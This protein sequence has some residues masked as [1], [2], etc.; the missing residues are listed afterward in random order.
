M[1]FFFRNNQFTTSILSVDN[2]KFLAR[3]ELFTV[4]RSYPLYGVTCNIN[5]IWFI[6]DVS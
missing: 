1:Q 3:I 6:L 2:V 5:K 4:L